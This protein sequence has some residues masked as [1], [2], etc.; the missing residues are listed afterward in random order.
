MTTTLYRNARVYSPVDPFATAMLVDGDR[1]AWI[2]SEGAAAAHADS[3]DE[4]ID[5]GDA[6]IAPAFVD[7]HVHLTQTAIAD[8][9][10]EIT[11]ATD[12]EEVLA[13]V[14]RRVRDRPG[15]PVMGTGWDESGWP[16]R[17]P[18]SRA[19]LDA[20]A[21][22]ALVYLSRR[23][24]HSAVVS[25]AVLEADPSIAELDGWD[26]DDVL[27]R[28]QAG[29]RAGQLVQGRIPDERLT[30]R[31]RHVLRAAAALGIGAIHEIGAPRISGY[32]DLLAVMELGREPGLA[33]VIGYWGELGGVEAVLAARAAGA[34]GDLSMDGSIGSRSARLTLPYT[35]APDTR[36]SA[37]I[38]LESAT[39]HVVTCTRAGLQAG[40]HCIGDEGVAI[41][42]QAIAAAAEVCGVEAV[43]GARHRLDHV[44]MIDDTLIA[45]MVRLGVAASVQPAFDTLWGGPDGLYEQRLGAERAAAMNPFAAMARA[46]V[47]LAFGSDAPVTPLDGWGMVRGAVHHHTAGARLSPRGAF[48]AATRGGWRAAGVDDAGVL[49]PGM[50]ASFVL[51]QVDGELVVEAPDTRVA[52][53]STDPRSGVPG[54]PDLNGGA[55]DPVCRRT[56]VGGVVAYDAMGS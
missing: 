50:L 9:G 15:E 25:T 49:A 38:D 22:G 53:W 17:R 14:R 29:H 41:A 52:A 39:D 8:D 27:I 51:W 43:V 56:V 40:F 26:P 16:S 13:A 44:E 6:M 23:D 28:R 20:A 21:E 33:D 55:A 34:A 18:P 42:V 11:G 46:G 47:L 1:I 31:R 2:G 45:E 30:A 12:V 37:Y 32:D 10:V 7:A 36:G 4:V 19:E 3:V 48:S 54:L 5:A 24:G 35:D